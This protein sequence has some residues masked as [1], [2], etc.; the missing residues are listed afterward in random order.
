[1]SFIATAPAQ[2]APSAPA[3]G[4][5]ANDGWWPDIDPTDVRDTVRL[6]G[7]VTDA[8]L[9][10]SLV[11]SML[12][13]NQELDDWKALQR[14]AGHERLADI[15]TPQVDGESRLIALYRRAVYFGVKADLT[16]RYRD[17]DTTAAG[18]RRADDLESSID[19]ARRN[20]RWAVSDILGHSRITVELM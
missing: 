19:D 7:S 14:A 13:I 11:A 5:I 15:P 10:E 8:R 16:E 1:M 6:N 9:R 20:V 2:A 12:S 4:P 17:F 3:P 18:D